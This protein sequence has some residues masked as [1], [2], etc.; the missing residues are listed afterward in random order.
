MS[1]VGCP[2]CGAG[3]E[4]APV[5]SPCPSCGKPLIDGAEAYRQWKAA[6][7]EALAVFHGVDLPP[8]FIHRRR[9]AAGIVLAAAALAGLLPELAAFNIP[10]RIMCVAAIAN[11]C[12][13]WLAGQPTKIPFPLA[14]A[15]LLA[16]LGA[17]AS[18]SASSTELHAALDVANDLIR[19]VLAAGFLVIASILHRRAALAAKRDAWRAVLGRT[20]VM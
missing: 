4:G 18:S 19:Y 1:D 20:V 17:V 11:T 7:R 6:N 8:S 13:H 3:V 12:G 14:L 2:D 5:G 10:T 9:L 16:A 15:A